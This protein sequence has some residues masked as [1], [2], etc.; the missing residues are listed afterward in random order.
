[1]VLTLLVVLLA[2]VL[3]PVQKRPLSS[4]SSSTSGSP[5][6]GPW[7][8]K[9]RPPP[10][11][12]IGGGCDCRGGRYDRIRDR[13]LKR[14]ISRALA[15]KLSYTPQHR[16]EVRMS[17]ADVDVKRTLFQ[18]YALAVLWYQT[19]DVDVVR[20]TSTGVD[21]SIRSTCRTIPWTLPRTVYLGVRT[22]I[23]CPAG[24]CACGTA[25]PATL[26]GTLI[27]IRTRCTCRT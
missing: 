7:G 5:D 4:D 17:G 23:G 25:L 19:T 3:A 14:G 12:G 22:R 8:Y 2:A 16:D 15:L 26:D 1:M 10:P 13:I 21:A 27:P 20:M 24:G 9:P 11:P 18:H 6:R